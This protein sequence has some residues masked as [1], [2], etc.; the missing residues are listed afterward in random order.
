MKE[1]SKKNE[2]VMMKN[3]DKFFYNTC[4][5]SSNYF[6][7]M[8]LHTWRLAASCNVPGSGTVND[9]NLYSM[10]KNHFSDYLELYK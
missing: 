3:D 10:V 6:L 4:W 5:S 9:D 8:N 1:K 7:Y 2:T